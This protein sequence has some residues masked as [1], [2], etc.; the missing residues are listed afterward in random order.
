MTQDE[1]QKLVKFFAIFVMSGAGASLI[2]TSGFMIK[3]IPLIKDHDKYKLL[4][5]ENSVK[6]KKE[7]EKYNNKIIEYCSKIKKMNLTD[8]ELFIKFI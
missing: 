6:Y 7:I 8:L 3:K 5:E 1:I 2:T 4:V